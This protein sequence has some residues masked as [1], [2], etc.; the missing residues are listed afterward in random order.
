MK[1]EV[2]R[3]KNKTAIDVTF[4]KSIVMAFVF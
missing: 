3:S 1:I 4:E 2:L